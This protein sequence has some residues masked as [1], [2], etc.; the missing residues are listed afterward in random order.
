ML[1]WGQALRQEW[2]EVKIYYKGLENPYV[3]LVL[4]SNVQILEPY[5][6]QTE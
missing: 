4:P 3:N 6:L 5:F 2:A 1:L